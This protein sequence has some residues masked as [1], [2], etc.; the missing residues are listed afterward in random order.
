MTID[1]NKFVEFSKE[2]GQ[3]KEKNV[4]N[5]WDNS[6]ISQIYYVN[7]EKCFSV[8]P[9]VDLRQASIL[10]EKMRKGEISEIRFNSLNLGMIAASIESALSIA[11]GDVSHYPTYLQEA[12]PR[13][14]LSGMYLSGLTKKGNSLNKIETAFDVGRV[15]DISVREIGKQALKFGMLELP[16]NNLA[17]SA[18]D[19]SLAIKTKLR[20]I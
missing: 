12:L 10:A 20:K 3:S 1:E 13:E 11:L 2:Y 7:N 6:P 15:S 4:G 18:A 19:I 14:A 8:I 5:Y 9:S 17:H 16:D